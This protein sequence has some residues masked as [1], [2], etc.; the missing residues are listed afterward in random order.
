MKRL[1]GIFVVLLIAGPLVAQKVNY[2]S[3]LLQ[4]DGKDIAKIVRIKDKESFGLTSTYEL[5]NLAGEKLIIAAIATNFVPNRNDNSS[6]YYQ[7][8]FLPVDKVGIFSLGKLGAEKSFAKL[9]GESG[10]IVN[11][12][13]DPKLVAEMLA[14]KSQNPVVAV[15]YHLVQRDKMGPP[16]IKENQIFQA[17]SLI[18]LFKDISTRKEFDTYEFRLPDGLV[19][20]Q[21]T[22]TGGNGAQNCMVSTNKDGMTQR[23][24]IPSKGIYGA[25]AVRS[26][27]MDRN[28]IVLRQIA[29]W[30]VRNH[31]L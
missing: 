23:A 15:E 30:L 11:D 7:F 8:T 2:K 18:G 5:Y 6:Y 24:A 19:V 14:R 1:I 28:E 25:L 16:F 22:F 21:V 31:Y 4:V 13:I 9:I 3:G 26:E 27:G 17:N 10:I 20:A 29:S 12:Q